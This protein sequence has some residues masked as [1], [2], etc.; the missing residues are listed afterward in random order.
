MLEVE[1]D[2]V[3]TAWNIFEVRAVALRSAWH[4]A[5]VPAASYRITRVM[6]GRIHHHL[7]NVAV[8]PAHTEEPKTKTTS[9]FAL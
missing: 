1:Q 9:A 5:G 6:H 4:S 8:R 2:H 7:H 3:E